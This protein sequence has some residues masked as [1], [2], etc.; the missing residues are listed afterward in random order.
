MQAG[1]TKLQPMLEGTKQYLVPLFQRPYSWDAKEWKILWADLTDLCEVDDPRPHFMGSIVT[2]PTVSVPEGV[3]KYLLI[4]G[5]QRLTTIFVLLALLRDL[6]KNNNQP[7]LAEEINNTLLVNPY[8][9][10]HDRF[11][12][13]PTQ[14]DR[15]FFRAI[16]DSTALPEKST[17]VYAAYKFFER[18]MRKKPLDIERLKIVISK[19]LSAVSIVLDINDNPHL[20]FEGLNAKGRPLTQADLIRNYFVMRVHVDAQEDVYR[21]SWRPM[22]ESLGDSLTEFIRHYLIMQLG[23]TVNVNDVYFVLKDQITPTNAIPYLEDLAKHAV[24]YERFLFPDQ[25]PNELLRAALWRIR[26]MEVGVSYPFLLRCYAQHSAGQLSLDEFID[27]LKVLEN[28]LIRRFVS[29][30]PTYGLNKI[31]PPLFAQIQRAKS[32][33][34]C[35]GLKVVL[36]SKNYPKDYDFRAKLKDAKLYGPGDRITKTKLILEALESAYEHK[37]QVPY[38]KLTIEHVI[39]QTLSDDWKTQ[40]GS[41]WQM[42]HELYLHTL[43]NLTLT[44]Y[45]SEL[46][47]APYAVKRKLLQESHI[48][49]NRSFGNY[50]TW[51]AQTIDDRAAAL[52][53]MAMSVWP[54]FGTDSESSLASGDVVGKSPKALWILGQR[55]DVSSWRDVLEFTVD[56]IADL[57]PDGFERILEEFPRFVGRDKNKFR[58]VRG[59]KCGAFV[60]VNLGAEAIYRFCCQAIEALGLSSDDWRVEAQ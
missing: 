35:D 27:I 50:E 2:M 16:I 23:D 25:E 30:V 58:S 48:E 26:R 44:A 29:N 40:L 46:S 22:Q 6:A 56:T 24:F 9:M 52:S 38:D 36:Q 43:G 33:T 13:Q 54:Y 59:L 55:Y 8:K 15:D 5:Q 41:D 32:K 7:H 28:F 10:G 11:K 51:T 39:P 34:L 17:Q 45:N 31:F 20:V 21:K 37:E 53:E 4:D 60:E 1:E 47:N 57:E 42:V 19:T 3:S 18:E 14:V 49:L 12:L